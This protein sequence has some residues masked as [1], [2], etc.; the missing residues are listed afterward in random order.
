MSVEKALAESMVD[1]L[2]RKLSFGVKNLGEEAVSAW[3]GTPKR[4]LADIDVDTFS[5]YAEQAD[6]SAKVSQRIS[7]FSGEYQKY[8]INADKILNKSHNATLAQKASMVLDGADVDDDLKGILMQAGGLG[9]HQDALL[10]VIKDG[11][12][13]AV[14]KMF[15]ERIRSKA[16]EKSLD[17]MYQNGSDLFVDKTAMNRIMKDTTLGMEDKHDELVKLINFSQQQL[18]KE[19]GVKAFPNVLA[20]WSTLGNGLE[21]NVGKGIRNYNEMGMN[22][23]ARILNKFNDFARETTPFKYRIDSTLGYAKRVLEEMPENKQRAMEFYIRNRNLATRRPYATVPGQKGVMANPELIPEIK[24]KYDVDM[25]YDDFVFANKLSSSWKDAKI[26]EN[27]MNDGLYDSWMDLPKH[28]DDYDGSDIKNIGKAVKGAQDENYFTTVPTKEYRDHLMGKDAEFA[29]LNDV[30][31][32]NDYSSE[33]KYYERM[34]NKDSILRN[35][36]SKR[37]LPSEALNAYL[38]SFVDANVRRRGEHLL[39][40]AKASAFMPFG[41]INKRNMREEWKYLDLIS[42]QF[43]NNMNP[44]SYK[45][46]GALGAAFHTYAQYAIP[47]ALASPR[48]A[49]MNSLQAIFTGGQQVG[50]ANAM[51]HT[52]EF[53]TKFFKEVISKGHK[54]YYDKIVAGDFDKPLL[55]GIDG[56]FGENFYRYQTSRPGMFIMDEDQ[57]A[58]IIGKSNPKSKRAKLAKEIK[59]FL[60]FPFEGSDKISRG[61]MFYAATEHGAKALDN[62]AMNLKKGMKDD[63]AVALLAKELHLGSFENYSDMQYILKALKLDDIKGSGKEFLYRYADRSTKLS[64]FDYSAMGQSYIK[65]AAKAMNPTLGL[66]L[67][68]QSWPMYFHELAQGAVNSWQHGDPKPIAKLAVAGLVTYAGASYAMGEDSKPTKQAKKWIEKKTGGFGKVA[69]SELESYPGYIKNRAPFSSYLAFGEKMTASPS[70]ILTPTIG[71][72]MWAIYSGLTELSDL[73]SRGD[74]SDKDPLNFAAEVAKKHAESEVTY[75]RLLQ[76]TRVLKTAGIIDM[77]LREYMLK[78]KD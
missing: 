7:M 2:K 63:E 24:A 12:F 49:F 62:L 32:R 31:R 37:A 75:R 15:R 64:I 68:F 59:Q 36:E 13:S 44:A 66:M 52:A 56:T 72:G 33:L 69:I 26:L 54:R 48:M 21:T 14:R 25:G 53:Q 10:P 5:R 57:I 74:T 4:R 40:Q 3:K 76:G 55:K 6:V 1:F 17:D 28:F 22:W 29:E 27:K 78:N 38:N 58:S 8:K 11:D 60:A 70:G 65:G 61:G 45:D 41:D 50:Y 47:L 18:I 39:N 77:D 71:L 46:Q 23:T 16:I 35:D 67:T 73:F 20:K 51:K 30:L 19:S 34:A 43:K 9:I 42:K